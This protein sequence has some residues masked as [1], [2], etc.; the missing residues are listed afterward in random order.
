M[1]LPERPITLRPFTTD[2]LPDYAQLISDN[3]DQLRHAIRMPTQDLLDPRGTV[4]VFARQEEKTRLGTAWYSF[5]ELRGTPVGL[6]WLDPI[7]PLPYSSATISFWVSQPY[8]DQGIGTAALELTLEYAFTC[9]DLH[10]IEGYILETNLASQAAA[11]KAGG[12]IVGVLHESVLRKGVWS[13]EVIFEILRSTWESIN[14]P[15]AG[16]SS[17]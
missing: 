6:V 14:N 17:T 5:I 15:G 1:S 10:R 8:H 2:A 12:S 3:R 9:T 13:N 11:R 4:S 7:R 16:S